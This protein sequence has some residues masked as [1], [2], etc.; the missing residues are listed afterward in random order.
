MDILEKVQQR[1]TDL[2]KRVEHLSYEESLGQLGLFILKKRGLKRD[3]SSM[4]KYLK[5]RCKEDRA[6]L[7][8]VVQ[9]ER[10]RGNGNKLKLK[11]FCLSIRKHSEGE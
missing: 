5:E 2:I 9:S 6:R 4:Y 7:L 10:T 11:R 1:A 8:T 3:L